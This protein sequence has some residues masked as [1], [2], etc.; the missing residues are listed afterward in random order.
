MD[1]V[2]K[3]QIKI[4][5]E[6]DLYNFLLENHDG[7]MIKE[8]VS[9]RLAADNSVCTREGFCGYTDFATW[10]TGDAIN[11]LTTYLDYTFQDAVRVLC[12]F[13]GCKIDDTDE[14][15]KGQHPTT[16]IVTPQGPLASSSN[17]K[18]AKPF[19]LPAPIDGQ[20]RQ[21][22]AYLTQTR[23]I[24]ADVVRWLIKEGV[25]YQEREHNNIVFVNPERTFA[26]IRGTNTYKSY[27]RVMFADPDAFWWFKGNGIR[28]EP[29][30][31]FV[32]EAAIDAISLY[33]LHTMIEHWPYNALYCSIAGVSN[34]KRI[35]RIKAGMD[36]A[37]LS[38]VL[39]VDNDAAGYQCCQRNPGCDYN[40][41]FYKDWNV[42]LQHRIE[43]L[44]I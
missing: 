43:Q 14:E 12:E 39:A 17:A 44:G 26:E 16:K 36:A 25:M 41:P 6:A 40:L 13:M 20:C 4:A 23:K 37:G 29:T 1:Y 24:P 3:E 5:K 27:H 18:P 33:C 31:A 11:F 8:G 30:I 38:T 28:S 22:Y 42:T 9:L 32:F 21:L 34:Q 35:D 15:D 7:E 2:T 10:E 19:V